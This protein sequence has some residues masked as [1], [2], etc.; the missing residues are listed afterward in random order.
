MSD[1]K[2]PTGQ[3]SD[4]SYKSRTGQPEIP[5]VSDN[6]PVEGGVDAKTADSDE[7]L[8]M[9]PAIRYENLS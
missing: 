2:I 6:A 1:T 8:G 5:V 7:Q 4:D 9:S 3:V